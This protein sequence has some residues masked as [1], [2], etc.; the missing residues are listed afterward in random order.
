MSEDHWAKVRKD[1]L[2]KLHMHIDHYRQIYGIFDRVDE[3]VHAL[4][5]F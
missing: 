5:F 2:N 3:L 1:L 4:T